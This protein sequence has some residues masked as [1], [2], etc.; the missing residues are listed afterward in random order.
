MDPVGH[1][2]DLMDPV[3]HAIDLMDPVS[4]AIDSDRRCRWRRRQVGEGWAPWEVGRAVRVKHGT[5]QKKDLRSFLLNGPWFYP[6]GLVK[7]PDDQSSPAAS[8]GTHPVITARGC[9]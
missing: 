6:T 8:L 3:S 7:R 2:I 4:Y 5:V 1:A 9:G